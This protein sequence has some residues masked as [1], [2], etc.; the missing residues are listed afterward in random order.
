M[1]KNQTKTTG[2][3]HDYEKISHWFDSH[4]N[5]ELNEPK[6][7][8]ILIQSKPH[9]EILDLGCGMGEPIASYLL[10]KGEIVY[11]VDG[12]TKLLE[13]AKKRLPKASWE[14]ADMREFV[15]VKRF[16][17]VIAWHSLS[18]KLWNY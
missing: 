6:Y 5:R 3:H 13:L 16:S 10:N 8:D 12:S 11:G 9:G 14:C 17:A 4:R 15:P 7:L 18:G 1:T 2:V